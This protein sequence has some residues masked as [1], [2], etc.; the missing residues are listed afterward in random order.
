[1]EIPDDLIK[2]IVERNCVVFVGAGLSLKAQ[3]PN[4]KELLRRMIVWAGK[5]GVNMSKKELSELEAHIQ[6][7]DLLL[8]AEDM[9]DRL[10]PEKYQRFM[11][12]V[13]ANQQ[14]SP[15]E[16][17]KLVAKIPF[18]AALTTNYDALLET[19]LRMS[20]GNIPVYTHRDVDDWLGAHRRRDFYVFKIHGDVSRITTVVLGRGDYRQLMH[21]NSSYRRALEN[22][23]SVRTV[24]FLAFSLTDPDILMLLD[25]LKTV[26]HGYLTHY[27]L[28]DTR[29]CSS[30]ACRRFEKDCGITVIPYTSSDDTHPQIRT[31]L[32]MLDKRVKQMQVEQLK[33][34][35]DKEKKVFDSLM[36]KAGPRY[37]L[38]PARKDELEALHSFCVNF[39]GNEISPLRQMC[40]WYDK[41]PEI[42]WILLENRAAGNSSTKEI[43]GYYSVI[44]LTKEAAELISQE[45]IT[46]AQFKAEH[47][48]RKD[49]KP[50]AI[51]LG[52][53]AAEGHDIAKG[54]GGKAGSLVVASIVQRLSEV[55]RN[56][57][58]IYSRPITDIG[59]KYLNDFGFVPVNYASGAL[60]RV[61]RSVSS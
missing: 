5:N 29:N 49:G 13:F 26:F 38:R 46:G 52:G 30:I 8:V 9:S 54:L 4:W 58:P 44:P 24:L 3:M 35:E 17:H 60:N 20:K 10:T 1:M 37:E 61:H 51:Y 11:T 21:N 50:A 12:E 55:R 41:N 43:V 28:M 18:A 34:D 23:F 56:R 33:Q 6:N 31:F 22:I 32:R 25:E 15:T 57:L 42:F 19:A 45:Q 59:L 27:A 53:I 7:N 16:A 2:Q 40:E 47:I 39:F 14:S 48:V 36:K